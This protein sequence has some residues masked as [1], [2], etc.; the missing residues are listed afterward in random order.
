M[1]DYVSILKRTLDGLG[2]A[3][4][5]TLRERV[6]GRARE[7]V[8][9][10]LDGMNPPPSD[11]VV[12]KQK[13]DLERAIAEVEAG[14]AE[15]E[16][17]AADPGTPPDT[18]PVAADG[19]S[20]PGDQPSTPPSSEA[21]P[22]GDAVPVGD[23]D[24]VTQSVGSEP[25]VP[26]ADIE[27]PAAS[28][29]DGAVGSTAPE[30]AGAD[31]GA[32]SEQMVASPV[33]GSPDPRPVPPPEPMPPIPTP[34]PVPDPTEPPVPEPQMRNDGVEAETIRTV[35]SD[36]VDFPAA[37]PAGVGAGA[38]ALASRGQS[39]P[40]S[41]DAELVPSD[42]GYQNDAG[43]LPPEDLPDSPLIGP[44]GDAVLDPVAA[45]PAL[46]AADASASD[47]AFGAPLSVIDD[48]PPVEQPRSGGLDPSLFVEPDYVP[49]DRV[50]FSPGAS[51]AAG[52]PA[53]LLASDADQRP[54]GVELQP[55]PAA[56]PDAGVELTPADPVGVRPRGANLMPDAAAPAAGVGIAAT[57]AGGATTSGASLG[58]PSDQTPQT[59][60]RAGVP[61]TLGGDASQSTTVASGGPVGSISSLDSLRDAPASADAGASVGV[62]GQTRAAET[63]G[64]DTKP[65]AGS[66]TAGKPKARRGGLIAASLLV[67]LLLGG[68]YVARDQI[69]DATGVEGFRTAFGL[70]DGVEGIVASVRGA[71]E[72][73]AERDETDV[74]VAADE[75]TAETAPVET[76]EEAV[77]ETDPPAPSEGTGTAVADGPEKFQVQLD[78]DGNEVNVAPSDTDVTTTPV[79]STTVANENADVADENG[80]DSTDVARLE[81]PVATPSNT[82]AGAAD[83]RAFLV[84][85]PVGNTSP[86]RRTGDVTW[87]VVQE[88]P[89]GDLPPE[90]AIQG[91]VTLPDGTALSLTV[92]RNADTSLPASHLI[93]IVFVTPDGEPRVDE[94]PLVGF[95]DSLQVSARPLIA[96]PAKITDEFFLVGLNNLGTAV[97]SNLD[98]MGSEEFMDVQLIF[99]TGR[100]A[101]LTLEKGDT[102]EG[103]FAEVLSA[104]ESNP[105]PG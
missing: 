35:P 58:I 36:E 73:A 18:P 1:A 54:Q 74:V 60:P 69:A 104:W 72:P 27:R 84:R 44:G 39:K 95:K 101:T 49:D 26:D 23:A 9:R 68:G 94:L 102:G 4:T 80:E 22:V 59:L 21:A 28:A 11:E 57:T 8:Q 88:S 30:V 13:G 53:A 7:A 41:S 25:P 5:P 99:A 33:I 42:T 96:V 76:V 55:D 12:A 105:L 70:E 66:T 93:E 32:R 86:D 50:G 38:L 52:P 48:V 10:Q 100:R 91:E 29:G 37:V 98:L 2:S 47:P 82:P 67:L 62:N 24:P 45:S 34:E 79:D 17:P 3:A 103:V 63:S 78:A 97:Q 64:T 51:E 85:E 14:Y 20:A 65:L 16:A 90:P 77:E 31:E 15:P 83:A 46:D 43:Y 56:D 87:S 40:L 6:Y 71:D 92:K 89:G 81:D 61:P 19:G 75:P